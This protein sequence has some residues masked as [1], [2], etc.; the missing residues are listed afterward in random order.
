ME[1]ETEELLA[2]MVSDGEKGFAIP[3][4]CLSQVMTG[5]CNMKAYQT[6]TTW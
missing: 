6:E 5:H 1:V 2:N 3:G 4:D